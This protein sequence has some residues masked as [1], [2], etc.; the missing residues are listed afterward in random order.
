MNNIRKYWVIAVIAGVA[1]Q[2]GLVRAEDKE[3]APEAGVVVDRDA[4]ALS[5]ASQEEV[6]RLRQLK[7][8]DPE[9]FRK[10]MQEK[11]AALRERMAHLKETDPEKF[12]RI[13]HR[14]EERQERKLAHLK[15]HNPEKYEEV[16]QRRKARLEHRLEELKTK[17]P[18]RYAQVMQ[19]RQEAQEHWKNATPEQ[20]QEWLKQHPKFDRDNNPP[21]PRG[22]QG[23]NWDNPPGPR[24]GPG[25]GPHH[26]HD[27]RGVRDHGQG[28]GR[29]G[30]GQGG[31][32]RPSGAGPKGGPH[33][34]GRR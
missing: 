2:P 1:L 16:M 24:G 25:V 20:R 8:Q 26:P 29:G 19:R 18:E 11:K 33:G 34:G 13:K 7:Q 10:A 28:E 31:E 21:G 32:R 17:N 5:A 15:E 30:V 12:Q 14:M 22:G 3:V 9:A 6:Q 4:P 23:T 27:D